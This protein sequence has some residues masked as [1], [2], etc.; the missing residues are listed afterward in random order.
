MNMPAVSRTGTDTTAAPV[1][2]R[3]LRGAEKAAILFLCLGEERGSA[4]MRQLNEVDIQKITR[5]M[6]TLG[7]VAAEQVEEVMEEFSETIT[8]GG[9]VVGSFA[10]AETMLRNFLPG[11]RVNEILRDIRG[12]I[13]ER[14]LWT[15]FSALNESVIANFLKA[16]HAQTAAAILTNVS[17][18]VAARVLP[19][20]GRDRMQEIIERMI[21]MESVPNH[22]MKQIEESLQNDVM[23]TSSQ[24][25]AGEMQQ[26][27]ANLFNRLD[28]NLFDEIT[29]LLEDT[30][31]DQF[32]SIRQKMFTFDD[33]VAIDDQGIQ[34]ILR[35]I[36]NEVLTVALK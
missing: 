28:Q 13:R 7:T 21:R 11:D 24:P 31:P 14:D 34:L 8:N 12:P 29:P 17:S 25:T 3:R 16:E 19:L 1:K 2:R 30:L 26:R 5:A 9:P 27:M 23:A 36:S 22:M 4:L 15:K 10:V 20:L 32:Q 35:E 33:L 6:S 18:D